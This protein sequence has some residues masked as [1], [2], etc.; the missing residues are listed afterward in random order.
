MPSGHATQ[1]QDVGRGKHQTG[2]KLRFFHNSVISIVSTRLEAIASR[3]RNDLG[4]GSGSLRIMKGAFGL[5]VQ[6]PGT[7]PSWSNHA[8]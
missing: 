4:E 5:A 6:L 7:E 1:L 8:N 3:N 2:G